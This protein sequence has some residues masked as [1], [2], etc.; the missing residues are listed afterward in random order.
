[1]KLPSIHVCQDHI[2]TVVNS[3]APLVCAL[4]T[5]RTERAKACMLQ[6]LELPEG[7]ELLALI[8]QGYALL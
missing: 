8:N 6:V 4:R 7:A 5:S 1:M 3:H 2:T